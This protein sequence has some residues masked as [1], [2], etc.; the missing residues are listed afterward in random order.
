MA[1]CKLPD[2]DKLCY[3]DDYQ[4]IHEFCSKK[5][6]ELFQQITIICLCGKLREYWTAPEI[7]R[8]LFMFLFFLQT[9]VVK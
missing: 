7:L 3:V 2:C 8:H 5:H 1:W 4:H 9:S 6:A